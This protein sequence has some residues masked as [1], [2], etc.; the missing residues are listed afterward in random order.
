MS[1][2]R[3]LLIATCALACMSASLPADAR[4]AY[5]GHGGHGGHVHYRGP[6]PVFWGGIGL[7]LGVGLAYGWPWVPNY[8]VVDAP[9]PVIVNSAPVQSSV[10][11]VAPQAATAMPEP[12]IYPRNGQSAAQTDK[13]RAECVQWSAAQPRALSDASVYMRGIQACMDARGYSLR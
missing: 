5:G 7:G 6:G 2:A 4:G 9:P 8:V 11:P 13:D 10:A 12:V 1:Y 3:P